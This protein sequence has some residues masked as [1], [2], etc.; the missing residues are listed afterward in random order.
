M[1]SRMDAMKKA[2]LPAGELVVWL[3]DDELLVLP[4]GFNLT[5]LRDTMAQRSVCMVRLLWRVFGSSGHVCQPTSG[6]L[7]KEFMRRGRTQRYGDSTSRRI[8]GSLMGGQGKA[9]FLHD[10]SL[11]PCGVSSAEQAM[12]DPETG[13]ASC[14]LI[15]GSVY[16][17]CG[18]IQ[19]E[20][21]GVGPE[22]P[23]QARKNC[24]S[25]V[26]KRRGSTCHNISTGHFEAT[27][28]IRET[29]K[30]WS[31]GNK[32]WFGL[33]QCMCTG[34]RCTARGTPAVTCH[35]THGSAPPPK[36]RCTAAAYSLR[37]ALMRALSM[38]MPLTSYRR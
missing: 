35:S 32:S 19:V 28:K 22:G 8:M 31:D 11:D 18:K 27:D 16:V 36:G 14:R 17:F 2:S 20:K 9:A 1:Q 23:R 34:H 7:A 6:N 10:G 26:R 12:A 15:Q 5:S 33:H 21:W 30:R 4:D 13:R 37:C 29:L 25:V 3:D 24:A 38:M